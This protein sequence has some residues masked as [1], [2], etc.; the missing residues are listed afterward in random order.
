MAANG[1][2]QIQFNKQLKKSNHRNA[3]LKTSVRKRY[4]WLSALPTVK[5]T[6]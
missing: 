6:E 4:V 2:I 1:K 5:E 3:P